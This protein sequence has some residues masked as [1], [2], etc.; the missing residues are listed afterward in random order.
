MSDTFDGRID[1]DEDEFRLDP[2]LA[3]ALALLSEGAPANGIDL[4]P[5]WRR[6]LANENP[7]PSS[8][9]KRQFRTWDWRPMLRYAGVMACG[10]GIGGIAI[11][12]FAGG[13]DRS[14][15]SWTVLSDGGQHY[16]DNQRHLMFA[17]LDSAVTSS[18]EMIEQASTELANCVAC[19]DGGLR[20]KLAAWRP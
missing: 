3:P 6:I 12:T 18:P 10:I 11:A 13:G 1:L 16:S 2:S 8:L 17:L 20:A 19:H 15:R 7:R 5:S 9:A 14:N 4:V